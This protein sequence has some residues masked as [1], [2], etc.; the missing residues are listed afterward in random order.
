MI[1]LNYFKKDH[2]K[3]VITTIRYIF[4]FHFEFYMQVVDIYI[5]NQQKK[6]ILGKVLV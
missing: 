2:A 5:P 1:A 4:V 6:S 3:L